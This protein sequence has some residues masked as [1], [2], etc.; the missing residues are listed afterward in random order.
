MILQEFIEKANSYGVSHT[1]FLF[2]ID[3]ELNKPFL[4]TFHEAAKH[5]FLYQVINIKNAPN[6][7]ANLPKYHGM[8]IEANINSLSVN[9]FQK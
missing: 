8:L 4:Y 1:P 7:T 3:F 9:D 6:W 5:T 2:L